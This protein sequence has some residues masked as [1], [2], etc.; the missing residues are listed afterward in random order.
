[1]GSENKSHADYTFTWG[2]KQEMQFNLIKIAF[3]SVNTKEMCWHNPS[4][5][6]M[7][8]NPNLS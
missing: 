4:E 1:M 7:E 2:I 5:L 6:A 8:T 3:T